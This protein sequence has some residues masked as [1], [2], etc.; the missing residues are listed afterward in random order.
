MVDAQRI[1]FHGNTSNRKYLGPLQWPISVRGLAHNC[2]AQ[3]S[4]HFEANLDF[5]RSTRPP[6]FSKDNYLMSDFHAAEWE[7]KYEIAEKI[8]DIRSK[9]F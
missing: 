4:L 9:E 2:I 3:R 8:T 6:Q 1:G 7:K 5:D